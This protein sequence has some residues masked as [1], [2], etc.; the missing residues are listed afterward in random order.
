MWLGLAADGRGMTLLADQHHALQ[1]PRTAEELAAYESDGEA[2]EPAVT[3]GGEAAAAA[4]AALAEV[5]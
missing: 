3:I 5:V 2:S 1:A 4:A